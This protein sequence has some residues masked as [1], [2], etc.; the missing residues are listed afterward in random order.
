MT[1]K[2]TMSMN[3]KASATMNIKSMGMLKAEGMALT[4]IT[5]VAVQINGKGVSSFRAPMITIGG[6]MISFG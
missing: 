5:G 2:S 4:N 3:I 1:I 6:G